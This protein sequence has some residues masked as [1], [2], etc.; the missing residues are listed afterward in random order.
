M[1]VQNSQLL[2]IRESRK[3]KLIQS[4]WA[5]VGPPIYFAANI[6]PVGV[7]HHNTALRGQYSKV[8]HTNS[9]PLA[10]LETFLLI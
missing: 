4:C 6:H 2:E 5:E 3:H 10:I 9:E 8:Q 1:V 7:N